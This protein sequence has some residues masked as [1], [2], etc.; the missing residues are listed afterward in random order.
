[1]KALRLF[2]EFSLSV[3]SSWEQRVLYKAKCIDEDVRDL[4]KWYFNKE[5]FSTLFDTDMKNFAEA[6]RRELISVK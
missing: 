1:M 5:E 4:T 3:E 2:K 6:M